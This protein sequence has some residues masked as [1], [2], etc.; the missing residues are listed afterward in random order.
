[1]MPTRVLPLLL[2][3]SVSLRRTGAVPQRLL[4]TQ[5]CGSAGAESQQCINVGSGATIGKFQPEAKR[6]EFRGWTRLQRYRSFIGGTDQVPA[7][8]TT[9]SHRRI[10]FS[11]SV[12]SDARYRVRLGMIE[13]YN[14]AKNGTVI[15]VKVNGRRL[16]PIN[17]LRQYGC[18]VAFEIEASSVA[19]SKT[20]IISMTIKARRRR[21]ASIATICVERDMLAPA[22]C[23]QP[24][25]SN[26]Q[27]CGDVRVI[28][29]SLAVPGKP[30]LTQ[31][32]AT[33]PLELPEGAAVVSANLQ[34]A[35]SGL[36][37]GT[38]T[39]L[40][41]NGERI[42]STGMFKNREF[43]PFYGA[44]ADVTDFVS[45]TGAAVYNVSDMFHSPY[46]SCP[47]SHLAAW[48]ITVV[49]ASMSAPYARINVCADNTVS[50]LKKP[51][52]NINCMVPDVV[53]G[54][55]RAMLVALEGEQWKEKFSING[56]LQGNNIFFGKDGERLDV[57]S[58]DVASY[59]TGTTTLALQFEDNPRQDSVII[60]TRLSYQT[61]PLPGDEADPPVT[62][63]DPSGTPTN[64]DALD[65]MIS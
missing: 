55:A 51:V 23:S 18:N 11:L 42:T 65:R 50:S 13:S 33:A 26:W 31:P 48:S 61:L 53:G 17:P 8:R 39:S 59:L 46:L 56:A 57:L 20:G 64:P 47:N 43:E 60:T 40:L 58:V 49:Y 15:V 16:R 34:W 62:P 25:C 45:S 21:V 24:S 1:M 41:L 6:V 14:C 9:R 2:L 52:L 22:P 27:G 54:E 37:K 12:P 28:H 19:P 38:D 4:L 3:L 44:S 10:R 30:C 63:D 36:P 29:G 5:A 7:Y 35:A 32:Y